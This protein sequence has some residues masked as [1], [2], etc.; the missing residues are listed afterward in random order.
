MIELELMLND[1]QKLYVKEKSIRNRVLLE[2]A[3]TNLKEYEKS[4][5][6]QSEYTTQTK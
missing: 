3:I 5:A 1:L 4:L 2:K 6:V